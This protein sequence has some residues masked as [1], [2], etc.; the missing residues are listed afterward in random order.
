[1]N[2]VRNLGIAF[3][4][5]VTGAA[6]LVSDFAASTVGAAELVVYTAANPK[7]H[8]VT[9]AAFQKAFPNIKVSSVKGSTGP[10]ARRAIAEKSNPQADVIYAINT[11]YL[12]Q[13]KA[14]GAFQPYEP[15]NSPIPAAQRDPDGFFVNEYA[16]VYGM[17]VNTKL[18]KERNLPMPKTWVDLI[19]PIY[20][21]QITI[22]SPT[23]SGTGLDIF[24]T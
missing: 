12:E 18:L 11:F 7:R 6:V 16:G 14:A 2:I 23:K 19:K 3:I 9:M 15:K 8:K 10:M 21:G 22:A 13:M 24:S 20:K 17:A 1:M 5:A 4:A